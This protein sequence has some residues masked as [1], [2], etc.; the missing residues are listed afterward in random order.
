MKDENALEEAVHDLIVDVCEVLYTHG[1]RTV[2]IGAIMRLIGIDHKSAATHDN[3][4]FKLDDEFEAL[5][6]NK[7]SKE[8][9]PPVRIPL[10]ATIH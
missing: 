5:I 6:K 2:P 9:A 1:Y 3:A 7:K 8:P 4:L 10:G